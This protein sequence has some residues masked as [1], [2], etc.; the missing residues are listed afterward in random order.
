MINIILLTV[1]GR[2][3]APPVK[4]ETLKKKRDILH[5]NSC[6][7]SSI[8]SV[9][10]KVLNILYDTVPKEPSKKTVERFQFDTIHPNS[11]KQF[12]I[13]KCHW[14][15]RVLSIGSE[16]MNNYGTQSNRT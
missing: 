8:N 5:V 7:I 1:N 12:R 13:A 10:Y 9:I 4:Y 14:L 15:Y 6:R 16:T 3:P 2:S 11:S